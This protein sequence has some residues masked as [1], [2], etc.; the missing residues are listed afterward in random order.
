MDSLIRF[1]DINT[2]EKVRQM[3]AKAKCYDM[4]V[5]RSETNFVTGHTDSIKMWSAKTRD[6]IFTLADAHTQPVCCAKFT[7]DERYIASTS[8]DSI[9]KIWDVRQ[10]KLLHE[11]Q[12]EK[13][14]IASNNVKLCISPNS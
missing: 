3:N 11:F 13:F 6:L 8:K 5:A 10:R 4:H 1:W 2:G 7:Q 12:N 9:L 14:K